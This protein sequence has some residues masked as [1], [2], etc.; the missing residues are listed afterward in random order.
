M[1]NPGD[2][3]ISVGSYEDIACWAQSPHAMD[4]L[5]ELSGRQRVNG[6]TG[7]PDERNVLQ[8]WRRLDLLERNRVA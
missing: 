6:K 4:D 3:I 7:L 1:L 2:V 5:A 8:P